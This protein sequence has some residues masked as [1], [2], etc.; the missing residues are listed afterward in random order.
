ML[1]QTEI[2]QQLL[3]AMKSSTDVHGAQKMNRIDFSDPLNFPHVSDSY[4]TLLIAVSCYCSWYT[5]HEAYYA[6]HTKQK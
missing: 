4:Y 6:S 3:H 2:S 5:T 1:I